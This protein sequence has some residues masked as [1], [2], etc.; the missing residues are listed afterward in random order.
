MKGDS[1]IVVAISILLGIFFG[2]SSC[3]HRALILLQVTDN[4]AILSFKKIRF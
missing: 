3:N 1:K 4:N 2:F